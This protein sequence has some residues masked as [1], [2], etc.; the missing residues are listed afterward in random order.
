MVRTGT[1]AGP[2]GDGGT[3]PGP[4]LP[5]AVHPFPDLLALTPEAV[6]ER[7]RQQQRADFEAA[8]RRLRE[9]G[10]MLP[11]L[12]ALRAALALDP[13]NPVGRNAAPDRMQ[14]LFTEL[15]EHVM[16]HPVWVHPFFRRFFDA[17][18][19]RDQ[20]A[21]FLC[22]YLNQVKNTRQCVALACGRF[23]S[24]AALPFG[25]LNEAV[26]ELVQVVLA[27]LLADEYGTD[28]QPADRGA[29]LAIDELVNKRTHI[30]LYRQLF[31]LLAVEPADQDVPF[32]P[33]VADNVLVQRL[34]AGSGA[35]REIEALASVGLGMEWGVPTI[36]SLLLGGLLR[37][38]G[39]EGLA[40]TPRH[41]EVL[42]G[43]V[44]QDVEHAIAVMVATALLVQDEEDV[45]AI[46]NATNML[47]ASR[48]AMMSGLY[49]AVF[50]E[51]CASI[52]ELDL[53]QRYRVAD[54]RIADALREARTR[55]PTDRV[56]DHARWSSSDHV[57][58]VFA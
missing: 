7:Y 48:Y 57:P 31:E 54:R 21:R 50:G 55:V 5:A 18:M 10:G 14:A 8:F 11:A 6:L 32:L 9:G 4:L 56:P 28:G 49:R 30:V 27:G 13:G 35:F 26:S 17:A 53:A 23:H 44:R 2:G 34:L 3:T 39:R 51:P 46:R 15:H 19:T 42:S 45:E 38:A 40:W 22:H 25:P 1:P 36:F 24:L 29:T 58:F 37:L 12:P 43:H 33:E 47:M 16:A 52:G 41:V 20:A